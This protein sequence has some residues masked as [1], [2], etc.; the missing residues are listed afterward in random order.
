M[1]FGFFFAGAAFL[2]AGV[3]MFLFIRGKKPDSEDPNGH[4]PTLPTFVGFWIMTIVIIIIGI[5]AILESLF[6]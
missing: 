4:G 5:V 2:I 1:D 6:N 3:L